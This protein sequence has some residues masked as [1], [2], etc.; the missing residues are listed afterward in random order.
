[1]LVSLVAIAP[2][3]VVAVL[4]VAICI[5]GT[6]CAAPCAIVEAPL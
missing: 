3:V 2:L 1:M 5:T 4:L 6:S